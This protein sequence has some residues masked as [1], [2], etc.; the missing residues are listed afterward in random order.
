MATVYSSNV[1]S[2]NRSY[3]PQENRLTSP[4]MSQWRLLSTIVSNEVYKGL[5]IQWSYKFNLLS[6]SI[7]AIFMFIGIVFF[8]GGG[9]LHPERVPSALL[10]FLV[11]YYANIAIGNMAYNLREEAQQGTLEK[12]YMSPA[13]SSVVLMGR[14]L[15]TFV[16]TTVTNV[17]IALPLMWAFD[18]RFPWRWEAVPVFIILLLGV[19]GFGF[20]I[21][22]ATLVFKNVGPLANMVQNAL[23]FLNGAFLAVTKFPEWLQAVSYTIPTTQGIHVLRRIILD[24]ESFTA[25]WH[26]GSLMWLIIHSSLYLG[27]GLV[28]FSIAERVAKKRGLLGHY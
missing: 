9:E 21:G 13:S 23:L 25:V 28:V 20:V 8:A 5:L 26:D 15:S 2:S 10:G 18:I 4:L 11:T 12:W 22:G 14:T 17:L 19:Y 3:P 16:V 1:Y 27:A 6:E 24:G 7:M